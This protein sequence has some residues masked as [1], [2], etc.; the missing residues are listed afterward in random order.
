MSSFS[1]AGYADNDIS[2]E[3]D[4][5]VFTVSTNSSRAVSRYIYGINDN[6]DLSGF[7]PTVIKQCS[8]AVSSYNWE[9][10]AANSGIS[11]GSTNDVS[12]VGGYPSTYW[13][14][15]AL[16]TEQ[17][18]SKAS[19]YNISMRLV[20]LQMMGSA[21]GDSLGVVDEEDTAAR[22]KKVRYSKSD[23][24]STRPDVQD[25]SIYMDEYVSFLVNM[26][27]TS[28]KGGINGYMLDTCPDKWA[29]EFPYA[30]TSK[31]TP[32]EYTDRSAQLAQAVRTI[33]GNAMIF[34]PSLSGLDGCINFG[35]EDEWISGGYAADNMW[36]VDYYLDEM[37]KKSDAAGQRLLDCFDIHYYTAARSPLGEDVLTSNDDTSDKYRMQAVRTLWDQDYT[38]N[39]VTGLVNKR[40]TP[41]LPTL[42][43]SLRVNYPDTLL[44]VSEYDFGG[45]GRMSGAIAEAEA[46]GTFASEGVFLACLAPSGDYRFQK[47]AIRLYTDYDGEGSSFGN[48]ILTTTGE[49]R[50]SAVYAGISND[51]ISSVRLV[52]TNQNL[53][54]DKLIDIDIDSGYDYRVES[55]YMI[56]SD[57]ADIV[58]ADI[59][60]FSQTDSGISFTAGPLSAYMIVLS[61]EMPEESLPDETAISHVDRPDVKETRPSQTVRDDT[62]STVSET[63]PPEE[64]SGTESV[65]S[66]ETNAYETRI[67]TEPAEVTETEVTEPA[68][69]QKTPAPLPVKILGSLLTGIALLGV[70]YIIVF[71][72]K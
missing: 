30:P 25:D 37:R 3:I 65:S 59:S 9:T 18:V 28:D 66:D 52:V 32:S 72:R 35:D 16:Y 44:S 33:D 62:D 67:F 7:S 21:A 15:P 8:T 40:F 5:A 29:E 4:H 22:W 43:A 11:G 38:E 26:Y 10:N 27:G 41:V 46:L 64:E 6:S 45:G 39:S 24:Y 47:A 17:L 42:Q 19:R 34:G 50:T 60:D 68:P 13:R 14:T 36:F 12:L 63:A 69:Q 31:V 54:M 51:D 49:D 56:D 20:T 1:T 58:E 48:G 57:T 2:D 61:G 70:F 55:A 53:L 71:D 23:A